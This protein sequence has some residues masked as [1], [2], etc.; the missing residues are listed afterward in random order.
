MQ[1]PRLAARYAK[2]LLDLAV[3]QNVLDAT[4]QDMQTLDQVCKQSHDFVVMLRSPVIKPHMKSAALNAVIGNKLQPLSKAF[5]TLLVNKGRESVLPEIA[6]AFVQQY[7]E[8]K[9][10]RPV[11]LTTA[12]PVSDSVKEAIRAKVA[13]N[14]VGQTV[15]LETAVDASLIG[16]FTLE[17]GDKL[18]DASVRRDLNDIKKQ[19]LDKS[20]QM[21]L[22]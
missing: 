19:F 6:T 3:E 12:M 4:L 8:L 14:M 10:I 5:T 17:I 18:V 21:Q 9:K 7:N 20:Y 22:R 1:N 13:G 16:G 11:R 2:S 15:Q